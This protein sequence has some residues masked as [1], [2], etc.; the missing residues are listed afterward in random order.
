MTCSPGEKPLVL[1]LG[2]EEMQSAVQQW[3][4]DFR[5]EHALLE[6]DVD[7]RIASCVAVLDA[8]MRIRFPSARIARAAKLRLYVAATTGADHVDADALSERGIP[9]LTLRGQRDVLANLTPAAEHS[10]LLMMACA[11]RLP[12]AIAHVL[13]GGWDRTRYP[14]TM[15]KG[16]TLGLIGCG[17]IGG[18]MSRYG[19]AF[20]MNVVGFDPKLESWPD[21]IEQCTMNDVLCRSDF[22]SVHVPLTTE[23]F[24]LLGPREFERMK[25]GVVLVNTSRGEIVNE[26]ALYDGL[27]SGHVGAAGV[28]VLAGEPQIADHPLLHYARTHDNLIITPHIGGFSPDAVRTVLE[29]SCGRIRSALIS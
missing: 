6:K 20:G 28:D 11:R 7:A 13:N 21:T 25:P 29:F 8:S 24:G 16:K 15:L 17:R 19:R 18:W 12:S 26:K 10:W 5:V 23:T 1:Y 22:L 27:V 2:P 9:L 3:L 4:P 14:G